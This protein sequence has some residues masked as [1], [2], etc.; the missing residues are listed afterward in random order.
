MVEPVSSKLRVFAANV[1]GDSASAFFARKLR[2][3][4]ISNNVVNLLPD[5]DF[6]T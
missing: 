2:I 5:G 3:N 4:K 1:L 6:T